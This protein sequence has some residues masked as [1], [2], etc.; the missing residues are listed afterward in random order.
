VTHKTLID[1]G[2]AAG[3][4][5]MSVYADST[6]GH[7][8]KGDGSPVT[9]ADHRA[10]AV[11]LQALAAE[12]PDIPAVAEEEVSA[13]RAPPESEKFFL[14]DPLD[15][16]RE[17]IERNGEFTVNIALIEKGMP[18]AGMIFAPAL[19]LIF[20]AA[21]GQAWRT[22]A[23]PGWAGPLRPITTRRAPESFA[24]IESR[25][26]CGEETIEWLS[27]F[28]VEILVS[29]GSSLKFCLIAC[30][31][32]DLYPRLGR[33]ME[34]DTAAGDAILRAA[35]GATT[36]IDGI[37]LSYGKRARRGEEDFA[38]PAFVAFGDVTL[39]D[40]A[41]KPLLASPL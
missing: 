40:A 38:N 6:F 4:E 19:G 14:V 15:G 20:A 29:R 3:R 25:V 27:R 28:H 23:D 1:I 35:G 31:E 36:T 21:E 16:T 32:A 5:I 41:G 13:G 18:V 10:E 7:K 17:F 26:N 34:W 39:S 12:Y 37:P 24:V 33:T 22:E 9:E 8:H 30:G 2:L 11:I